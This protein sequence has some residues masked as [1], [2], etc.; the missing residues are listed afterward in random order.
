MV[1]TAGQMKKKSLQ[2]L[3]AESPVRMVCEKSRGLETM[4]NILKLPNEDCRT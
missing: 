1:K 4:T 3:N 2:M